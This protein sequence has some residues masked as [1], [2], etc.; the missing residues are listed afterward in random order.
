MKK[1]GW[2]CTA[3]D[4]DPRLVSHHQNIIGISSLQGDLRE[5][6]LTEKFDLISFNKVLEHTENPIQ[7]LSCAKNFLSK[8]GLIYVELPDGEAAGYESKDREEFL[9]G[10]IHVF[11]FV[12][13]VLLVKKSNLQ[14]ISCE[15]IREPSSKYTLRGFKRNEN[16]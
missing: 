15:R 16:E 5:Q 9:I 8:N 1:K 6:K 3:I 12:S 11:S 10:H 2:N 13:Y 7:I 14:L 4:L